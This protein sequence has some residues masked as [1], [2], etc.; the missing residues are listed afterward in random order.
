MGISFPIQY[1][2]HIQTHTLGCLDMGMYSYSL[3]KGNTYLGMGTISTYSPGNGSTL[4]PFHSRPLDF[5]LGVGYP[6]A[7]LFEA[8]LP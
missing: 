4:R 7:A 6:C 8:P 5:G 2:S 3:S 1:H